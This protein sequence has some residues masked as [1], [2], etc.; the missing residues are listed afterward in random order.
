MNWAELLTTAAKSGS[1][2]L[3]LDVFWYGENSSRS[4]RAQDWFLVTAYALYPTLTGR[5]WTRLSEL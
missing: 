5:S 3:G 4:S 2:C 1:K